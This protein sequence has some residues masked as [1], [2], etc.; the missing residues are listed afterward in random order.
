[1][2]Y[3]T[4]NR[5]FLSF[6]LK[7]FLCCVL[8]LLLAFSIIAFIKIKGVMPD[9]SDGIRTGKIIKLSQKGIIFKSYEGTLALG[10]TIQ[11]GDGGYIANQWNFS[12]SD[13]AIVKQ[14]EEISSKN[15]VVTL[16]YNQYLIKPIKYETDYI[17]KS[18]K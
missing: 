1:M 9:Y 14:L 2:N 17:V 11:S 10:G 3:Y 8:F 13:P 4:R 18:V 15:V 6:E 7:L 16:Q 5:S 12:V